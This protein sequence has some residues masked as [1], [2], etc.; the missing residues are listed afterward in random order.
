VGGAGAGG[1]AVST[2]TVT[3]GA[4]YQHDATGT[5]MRCY[6]GSVPEE[7][8]YV[9]LIESEGYNVWVGFWRK[10]EGP[11]A[12]FRREWTRIGEPI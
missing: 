1:E 7:G 2:D 9:K 10:W 6:A 4:F 8:D 11:W 5:A 3:M 12:Q